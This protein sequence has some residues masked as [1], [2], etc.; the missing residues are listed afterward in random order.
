MKTTGA[1]PP[2]SDGDVEGEGEGG[3]GGAPPPRGRSDASG[4]DSERSPASS[5][6]NSRDSSNEEQDDPEDAD[7][8]DSDD[9]SEMDEG[10]CER[11]RNE[12]MEIIVDLERQF[13]GLREQL[14]KERVNQ[15]DFQLSEIRGGR[16]REYLGPLQRLQ[17]NMR[18][19]I[20][21]AG[22]LRK[23]RIE[24]VNNKFE[25]EQQA[26]S[27]NFNSEKSL[28]WD[29][30]H[31][32]LIEKIRK[33]EEDRQNIDLSWAGG[34]PGGGRARARR[35]AVTV[36]GPYIVYMLDEQ[37][38]MEDWTTIKKALKRTIT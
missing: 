38:I 32:E 23:L 15:V 37:D 12:C 18:S 30:I 11:R 24:N 14:Y 17:E 7:E 1:A 4:A 10:E 13:T 31:D 19:R 6:N 34:A 2:D 35:K 20:E 28:A 25:A 8:P 9:S 21:V 36:T 29:A 22:I 5:R 27:Q 26:A 33:L 3:A 16:S